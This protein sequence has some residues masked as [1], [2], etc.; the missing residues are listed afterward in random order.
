MDDEMGEGFGKKS[1][2]SSTFGE[3][4]RAKVMSQRVN[5]DITADCTILCF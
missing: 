4:Y 3:E 1:K 5:A 2:Y